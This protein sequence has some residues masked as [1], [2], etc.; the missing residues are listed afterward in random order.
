[1]QVSLKFDFKLNSVNNLGSNPNTS[2]SFLFLSISNGLIFGI[3][4]ILKF[5]PHSIL[6]CSVYLP[7]TN[8]KFLSFK[9]IPRPAEPEKL[10]INFNLF[11]KEYSEKNSSFLGT[12]YPSI[13]SLF[14]NFFNKLIILKLP[15]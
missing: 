13:F 10:D 2:L 3:S 9:I 7:S 5:F 15:F 12:M 6:A 1:M 4:N 11:G 8:R 14:I